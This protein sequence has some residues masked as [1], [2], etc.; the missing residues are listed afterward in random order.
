MWRTVLVLPPIAMSRIIA[1]S[2]AAGLATSRARSPW[3]AP[4]LPNSRAMATIR[5]DARSYSV[6]RSAEVAR[7]VPLPGSARPIASARQFMLFAVNMP[8]QL[9]QVG[10]AI[11]SISSSSSAE[12]LPFCR[13]TPPTK[14]SI[15]STVFPD[16]VR[17]ASIGPPET[18]IVG[19]FTRMA[20]MN[21]PGTIL[22]QLGM[23]IIAS[24]Q[25]A[26]I[27]VSTQS[28]ISSRDGQREFHAVVPHGDAVIHAD[29]VEQERH[30]SGRPDTFLDVVA[31]GLEM[32]V[33]GNDVDVAVANR[34]EG[35][36]PISLTDASG[37]EQTSMGGAG[38]ASLDRVGTHGA[39]PESAW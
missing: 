39:T 31:H 38:I 27:M 4:F 37:T 22:S 25:W 13:C 5:C 30:S 9:P 21:M 36:I 20:P 14:A 16:S 6:L 18:K 17:P 29:R 24:K 8:E 32:D 2:K 12:I 15:R 23:Q 33:A 3:P 35:L 1:L 11:F 26:W 34:D 28:A 7:I 10:Q 19:T